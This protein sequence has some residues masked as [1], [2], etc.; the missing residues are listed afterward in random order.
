MSGRQGAR[1]SRRE[2]E[3]ILKGQIM[4]STYFRLPGG[5]R[6]MQCLAGLFSAAVLGVAPLAALAAESPA[7]YP[8]HSIRFLVPFAAG[9]GTDI[10]ARAVAQAITPILGQTVYVEN[11]VGAQG[12]IGAQ[13]VARSAPDG[14][15]ILVGSIGTQAVNQYLYS[16]LPYDAVKDFAP[17]TRLTKTNTAM[18]VPVDSPFKTLK[19]LVDYAHQNPGKL[20]YAISAVGDAGH[21]GFEELRYEA[22]I[23]ATPIMYNSVPASITDMIGGRIDL[24]ITSVV[25]QSELIKSGK[26]RAIAVTGSERS[27]A[28]PNVPTVAESGYPGFEASSWSG[29]FA[30]AGTPPEILRKISDAVIKA[31]NTPEFANAMTARGFELSAMHPDEYTTFV[32]N[33]RAKWSKVIKEANIK[34]Q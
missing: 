31:Y 8:T 27:A 15:T 17:V 32:A 2:N 26:I 29:L 30:P 34:V 20:N 18:T 6:L 24:V 33:E 13:F 22:K 12:A 11:R 16:N 3:T 7:D 4:Y 1:S 5:R 21:L 19:D 25:A 23:D 14:Y 9:G 10:V 28:L